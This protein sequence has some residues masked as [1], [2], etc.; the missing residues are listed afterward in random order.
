LNPINVGR[1]WQTLTTATAEPTLQQYNV[2]AG[3][4]GERPAL[5]Q[6]S[7]RPFRV[8][9]RIEPFDLDIRMESWLP[10]D[11]IR[12]AGFG[13]IIVDGRHELT[14]ERGISFRSIGPDGLTLYDSGIYAPI[15]YR[16]LSPI[17]NPQPWKGVIFKVPWDFAF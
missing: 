11:T 8:R 12:R 10:T 3:R 2:I 16:R 4:V 13:H 7:D 5:V 1:A 6:T 9:L 15:P 14:L 17:P